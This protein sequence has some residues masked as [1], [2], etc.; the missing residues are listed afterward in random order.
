MFKMPRLPQRY[1]PTPETMNRVRREEM[2][3]AIKSVTVTHH[4][5]GDVS[6]TTTMEIS[7]NRVT[8]ALGATN[9]SFAEASRA[10]MAI[11]TPSNSLIGQSVK[12][13]N[14]VEQALSRN[15]PQSVFVR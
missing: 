14:E 11:A 7:R 13:V 2:D 12:D 15:L 9:E 4:A 3:R 5:D 10:F 1:T 8:E 6:H